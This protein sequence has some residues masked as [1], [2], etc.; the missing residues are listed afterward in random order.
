MPLGYNWGGNSSS[1]AMIYNPV[2]INMGKSPNTL[3][4][5]EQTEEFSVRYHMN[6]SLRNPKHTYRYNAYIVKVWRKGMIITITGWE[7]W[8]EDRECDKEGF[9]Y[10]SNVFVM[11][12][13]DGYTFLNVKLFISFFFIVALYEW[14]WT[15]SMSRNKNNF[16][17]IVP[18]CFSLDIT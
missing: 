2:P 9:I 11:R 16:L 15:F 17:E 12:V 1:E 4:K 7:E 6:R 14:K 8:I 5:L 10:I 18:R 3:S 13:G